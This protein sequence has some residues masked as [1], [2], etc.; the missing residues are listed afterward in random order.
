M[1]SPC[2]LFVSL[3]V[4]LSICLVFPFIF[5]LTKLMRSL[6]CLCAFLCIH[7]QIFS[8]ICGSFHIKEAYEITLQ[9][10]YR[11]NFLLAGLWTILVS[12][13][14]CAHINFFVFYAVRVLSMESR[15]LVLPRPS[16]NIIVPS[17]SRCS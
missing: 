14:T 4:C 7:P 1:R 16:C 10:V 9:S 15:R 11:F 5:R 13:S 6:R 8:F 17:T 3:S 2:R 12:V